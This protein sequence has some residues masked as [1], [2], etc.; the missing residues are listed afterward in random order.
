MIILTW[1]FNYSK[2]FVGYLYNL[3]KSVFY[4]KNH[5]KFMKIH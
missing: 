3:Y 2:K 4:V 1:F 5:L